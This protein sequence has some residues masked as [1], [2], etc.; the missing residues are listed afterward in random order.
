[1]LSKFACPNVQIFTNFQSIRSI[2]WPKLGNPFD[3]RIRYVLLVLL[4]ALA[5]RL[6]VLGVYL[7]SDDV[8]G[9][10]GGDAGAYWRL[11]SEP[12]SSPEYLLRG[13]LFP[14]TVEWI[15]FFW[16][17]PI[18]VVVFNIGISTLTVGGI[19]LL[20]ARSGLS[21][22][23]QLAAGLGIA[24][25]PVSAFYATTGLSDSLFTFLVV[26]SGI[27][28]LSGRTVLAGLLAGGFGLVKPI[29]QLFFIFMWSGNWR[30]YAIV[31]AIAL[32]PTLIWSA[33]NY[34]TWNVYQPSSSSAYN[35]AMIKTPRVI[36]ENDAGETY[37]SALASVI[38]QIEQERAIPNLER[39]TSYPLRP[40][41]YL[42]ETD[43][44]VLSA[45]IR[46][47]ISETIKRPK[48]FVIS[49]VKGAYATTIL[50][51]VG[52]GLGALVLTAALTL[53]I[54][55]LAVAGWLSIRKRTEPAI[56][57]GGTVALVIA[58]NIIIFGSGN[59]RMRMPITP[60]L[61]IL[62]IFGFQY[63]AA[64]LRQ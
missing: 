17:V 49:S 51:P 45:M 52:S 44:A 46:V 35:L 8:L 26:C 38:K 32:G 21:S 6:I 42:R 41:I 25:D 18:A 56:Y 14:E 48:G 39:T 5:I 4:A 31:G 20:A 11:S 29:G 55:G 40:Y 37:E 61:I 7:P 43:S 3:P 1:M 10:G 28:L 2:S 22:K 12:F 62:A 15:R 19:I 58:I 54:L 30:R 60:H 27:A 33:H 53:A 47:S 36:V 59:A 23:Y 57:L 16:D 13:P 64:R 34:V 63:Y 50:S 9:H 24:F